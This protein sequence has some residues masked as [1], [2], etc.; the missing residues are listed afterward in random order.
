MKTIQLTDENEKVFL[1]LLAWRMSNLQFILSLKLTLEER[2]PYETELI[3][4]DKIKQL[5]N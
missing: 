5:F 4:L 3:E 1:K 2:L